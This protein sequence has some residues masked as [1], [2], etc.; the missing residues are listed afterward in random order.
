MQ[1]ATTKQVRKI[2]RNSF[3]EYINRGFAG[4]YTWTD[5]IK[6]EAMGRRVAFRI[7]YG[8]AEQQRAKIQREVQALF[9]M[10]GYDNKVTVT[11]STEQQ[12]AEARLWSRDDSGTYLRIKAVLG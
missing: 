4:S 10:L 3:G 8:M 12:R 6:R 11:D 2:V 7:G 9:W 5:K 1:T